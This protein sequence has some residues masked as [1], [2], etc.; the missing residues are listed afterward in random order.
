MARTGD[1]LET[2]ALRVLSNAEGAYGA[3]VSVLVGS[4]AF[5]EEDELVPH[6]TSRLARDVPG[7]TPVGRV[8]RRFYIS[9]CLEV[10]RRS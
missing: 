1:A 5:G 9:Q 7:V 3:N 4:S 2:A 8:S 6:A 10:R